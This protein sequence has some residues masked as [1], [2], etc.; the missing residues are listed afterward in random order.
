MERN[1]NSI[2]VAG[3]VLKRYGSGHII[4]AFYLVE[5]STSLVMIS[6]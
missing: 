5:T 6:V 1:G 2:G 3:I 4:A